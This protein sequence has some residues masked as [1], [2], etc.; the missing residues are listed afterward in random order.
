[1]CA[2]PAALRLW[3]CLQLPK[4][5]Q[6]L[7]VPPGSPW[8]VGDCLHP[9]L[10]LANRCLCMAA[11]HSQFSWSYLAE[12]MLWGEQMPGYFDRY[13]DVAFQGMCFYFTGAFAQSLSTS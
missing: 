10:H 4:A 12:L 2:Q 3:Q 5:T 11:S 1:M 9:L 7:C 6:A 8:A 13:R